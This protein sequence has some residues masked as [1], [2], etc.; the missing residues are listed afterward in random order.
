MCTVN[1]AA[2]ASVSSPNA[3]FS[4]AADGVIDSRRE[5]LRLRLQ[6]VPAGEH[7]LVLRHRQCRQWQTGEGRHPMGSLRDM[8]MRVGPP[9]PDGH[10]SVDDV[11]KSNPRELL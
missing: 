9:F 1:A 5:S 4:E 11:R 8:E 6:D 10:G 7:V 3:A 2:G